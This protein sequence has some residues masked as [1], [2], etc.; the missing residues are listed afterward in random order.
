MFR[1]KGERIL[2]YIQSGTRAY[3][4]ASLALF[5]GGFVTFSILYTTQPLLPAFAKEFHV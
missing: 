4:R 3:K 2:T 5:L 1:R